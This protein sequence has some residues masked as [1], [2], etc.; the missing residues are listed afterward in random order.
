M[1]REER[2]LLIGGWAETDYAVVSLP[3]PKRPRQRI[4]ATV[5]FRYLQ[6]LKVP[7]DD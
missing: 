7:Q 2:Y 3:N 1:R 5:S 6:G 4:K